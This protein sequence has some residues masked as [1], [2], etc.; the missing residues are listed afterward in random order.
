MHHHIR[1]LLF[2]SP[3]GFV[4]ALTAEVHRI[5]SDP[6]LDDDAT[7]AAIVDLIDAVLAALSGSQYYVDGIQSGEWITASMRSR[8]ITD[9]LERVNDADISD[10]N[11]AGL[12]TPWQQLYLIWSAHQSMRESKAYALRSLG[13]KILPAHAAVMYC[14]MLR[15]R[16]IKAM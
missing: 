13:A 2:S 5:V 8:T 15:I 1:K 16:Q 3:R 9:R 11:I 4:P 14:D 10:C 6:R 12:S 7:A